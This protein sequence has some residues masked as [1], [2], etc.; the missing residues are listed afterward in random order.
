MI[1]DKITSEIKDKFRDAISRTIKTGREHAFIICRDD[2][3]ELF[4]RATCEGGECIVTM[5]RPESCLPFR[6]QGNFH[7]H[8]DVTVARRILKDTEGKLPREMI[9][10]FIREVSDSEGIDITTPSHGDLVNTLVN[11][12]MKRTEGTVCV[13]SDAKPDRVDCYTVNKRATKDD[14]NIAKFSMLTTNVEESGPP[15]PWIKPLF[16]IETI[17]L[18]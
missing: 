9:L 10:D 8:A 16:D 1:K 6:A 11:K 12:C 7:T 5:E 13:A 14:C 18:K 2:K 3:E 17:D 15:K 4:P